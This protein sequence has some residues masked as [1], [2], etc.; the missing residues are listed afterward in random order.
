[1]V[2]QALL[3]IALSMLVG[4]APRWIIYGIGLVLSLQSRNRYP[5]SYKL[6]AAAFGIFL[7]MGFASYALAIGLQYLVLNKLPVATFG[8]WSTVSSC[9]GVLVDLIAWALLF[10]GIFFAPREALPV[11]IGE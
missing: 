2:S 5:K 1:M 8:V 4:F 10:Y 9:G 6:I 3:T 7:T 11:V